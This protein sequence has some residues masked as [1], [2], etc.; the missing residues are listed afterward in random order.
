MEEDHEDVVD[1]DCGTA[2]AGYDVMEEDNGFACGMDFFLLLCVLVV[3]VVA[4][5]TVRG[6]VVDSEEDDE[7]ED[8]LENVDGVDKDA[9]VVGN[10]FDGKR[11]FDDD[12]DEEEGELNWCWPLLLLITTQ[13]LFLLGL[14]CGFWKELD[15]LPFAAATL[16]LLF[17]VIAAGELNK[18]FLGPCWD[19]SRDQLPLFYFYFI[20]FGGGERKGGR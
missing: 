7:E 10:C 18:R 13:L 14:D 5:V 1:D 2:A 6:S 4:V 16:V 15:P 11:E 19:S 3:V 9:A 8:V 20:L 17:V 12:E